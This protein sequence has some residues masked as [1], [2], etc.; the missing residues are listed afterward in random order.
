MGRDLGWGLEK[1]QLRKNGVC[2]FLFSDYDQGKINDGDTIMRTCLFL[3]SLPLVLALLPLLLFLGVNVPVEP[4]AI[5]EIM[6]L[7]ATP[8]MAFSGSSA[9]PF[10]TLTVDTYAQVYLT[11]TPPGNPS[12][13]ISEGTFPI[14]AIDTTGTYYQIE[15]EGSIGWVRV[16]DHIIVEGDTSRLPVF[17]IG[18]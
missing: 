14:R 15:Y 3:L 13:Y 16:D 18:Q 1:G 9:A 7:T 11:D 12:A 17:V 6:P 2:P 8:D 10:P 4:L 5:P